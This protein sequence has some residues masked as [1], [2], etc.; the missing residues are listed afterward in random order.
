MYFYLPMSIYIPDDEHDH[1]IFFFL[2]TFPN[3]RATALVIKGTSPTCITIGVWVGMG[4][5]DNMPMCLNT[6]LSH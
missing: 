4:Q 1:E 5:Y 6:D 3:L 2:R